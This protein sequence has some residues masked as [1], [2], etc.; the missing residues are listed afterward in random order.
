MVTVPFRNLIPSF[1]G[2]PDPLLI[3]KPIWTT[4]AKYGKGITQQQV[5]DFADKIGSHKFEISQLELDDMW[6]TKYGDFDV[7]LFLYKNNKFRLI[8]ENSRTFPE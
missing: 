3:E 6:T 1:L 7:S 5:V 8:L 4:W 2:Y